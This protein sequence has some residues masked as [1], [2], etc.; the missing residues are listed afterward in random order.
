MPLKLWR[1]AFDDNGWAF[2]LKYDGFRALAFVDRATLHLISRTGYRHRRY[3]PLAMAL[4]CELRCK[5]AVLDGEL[6]ALDDEGRPD[7]YAL[8]YRRQAPVFV[9]FDVLAV[10]GR[11]VRG[12]PLVA[13]KRRLRAIVPSLAT[14]CLRPD[15]PVIGEG[16]ALFDLVC[17][18]D[19]EE[20]STTTPA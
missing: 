19:L 17:A 12:E 7:F 16:R 2:E 9:V 6:A 11:D 4:R 5:T 1:E 10:D 15:D 14:S 18:R 8:L 3:D 13:H 20:N